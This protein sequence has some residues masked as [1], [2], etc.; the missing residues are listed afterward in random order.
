MLGVQFGVGMA[1]NLYTNLEPDGESVGHALAHAGA[2]FDAHVALGV[3][4]VLRSLHALIRATATGQRPVLF[5]SVIGSLALIGAFAAGMAFVGTND[6][7]ISL[8]MA[9]LTALAVASY[10]GC[11]Q[12]LNRNVT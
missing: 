5:A 4:I 11:L 7:A 6:A 12:L 2:T 10:V 8:T 1:V 9:L 3:L